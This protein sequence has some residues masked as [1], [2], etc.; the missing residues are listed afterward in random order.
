MTEMTRIERELSAWL[1]ETAMPRMPDY[2]DEILDETTRIRQRPRWT[3][4]R[5]WLPIPEVPWSGA[6][7]RRVAFA[8]LLLVVLALLLAAVAVFVGS[9]RTNLPA[10]FGNAGNGLVATSAGGDIIL[11]DPA[12]GA[13]RYIV[14]GET[15]DQHP[16]WSR[17]G[18]NVAFLRST[19]RGL[20]VV[21]AD[22]A[23]HIMSISDPFTNVDSD[24]LM[25]S[26]DSRQ[27]AFAGDSSA[28]SG[29]QV[30][31]AATG[32][33]RALGVWYTGL[34]MYWR[35]P[36]GRQLLYRTGEAG[37]GLALVSLADGGVVRL[38]TGDGDRTQL[39][40]LGWTPDGQR[41]LFQDD[42]SMLQTVVFDVETGAQ[43]HLDVAF[44]HVSN[45][46]TRVAGVQPNGDLGGP[47]CVVAITGG[48]CDVVEGAV[49]VEGPH[50]ASV[51]WSP[52][53]RWI[54]ILR[55]A[56]WLVD[57]T[58]AVPPR[59]VAG[60]GPGSWQRVAP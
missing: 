27:V 33:T 58:G 52:D 20:A 38:S 46:G 32:A 60:D 50:G 11:V 13:A 7:G 41:I 12:T 4:V 8:S 23:G 30:L 42:S 37:G 21:I 39:R 56:L 24:S 31:D 26:P 59:V 22:A 47:L 3:F 43:I 44:G 10:P 16:R 34:E 57:P 29:I 48:N 40:P 49:E 2:A 53:D 18:R 28:G 9:R 55:D 1:S 14:T 6:T 45:D 35:P 5:R 54:V 51:S 17:D 15:D 36:D 25:W 19:D